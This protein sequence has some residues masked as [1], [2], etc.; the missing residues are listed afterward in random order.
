MSLNTYHSHAQ[1]TKKSDKGRR[2][3]NKEV[4]PVTIIFMIMVLKVN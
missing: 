2:H 1:V 4:N 3:E